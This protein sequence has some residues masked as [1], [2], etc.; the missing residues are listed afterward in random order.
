MDKDLNL[1]LPGSGTA[2]CIAITTS[3]SS[4][5]G[6]GRRCT[7]REID[8]MEFCLWHMPLDRLE[9]AE[10][11]T[12]VL[13]CHHGMEDGES[14]QLFATKG[15]DPPRCK[16]H[17]VNRGSVLSKHAA[18]RRVEGKVMDRMEA[19]MAEHG[20]RL[21]D[22]PAIGNPLAELLDLAAE[23]AAWKNIMRDITIYLVQRGTARTFNGKV[24]EQMRAEVLL[25]ER[26]QER[27]AK[28]LI[29]ITKLGIEARLAQIE[30]Q[31]VDTVDRALTA[32]LAASGLGLV[33]QDKA[34]Q[35]LRRELVKAAKAG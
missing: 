2:Q 24:G 3:V 28:I 4:S 19:I 33:E 12:G 5:G 17:G 13:R 14:C 22:P 7:K 21:L 27:F 20:E 34:R 25:F 18:G 1:I 8:G 23:I 30:T 6:P 15:T 10:Q 29:D 31:Q 9:E 16:N 11:I 32:A 35:V 26:A